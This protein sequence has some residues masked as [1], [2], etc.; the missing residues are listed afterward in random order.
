MNRS[1]CVLIVGA[2]AFAPGCSTEALKRTTYESL[3]NV[4]DQQCHR[5]L[6]SDCPPRESYDEYQRKR[7]EL[8]TA[9]E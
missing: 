4:R 2:L 5:E 3:Q 6:S 9:D 7:K 8:K 1:C